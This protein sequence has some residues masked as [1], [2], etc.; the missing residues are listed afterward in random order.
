MCDIPTFTLTSHGVR[1]KVPL[2]RVRTEDPLPDQRVIAVLSCRRGS[3]YLGLL[4][5]RHGGDPSLPLYT[6]D[7]APAVSD[8]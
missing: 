4:L 3:H 6:V 1:A 2:I 7:R 8:I 5:K